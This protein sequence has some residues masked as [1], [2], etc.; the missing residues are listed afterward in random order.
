MLRADGRLPSPSTICG[1]QVVASMSRYEHFFTVK[2]DYNLHGNGLSLAVA[3][4]LGPVVAL[5]F[6]AAF[7]FFFDHL[8]GKGDPPSSPYSEGDSSSVADPRGVASSASGPEGAS[9]SVP[10]P[11][12]NHPCPLIPKE[13]RRRSLISLGH[14]P[15][16]LILKRLFVGPWSRKSIVI[17]LRY[18]KRNVVVA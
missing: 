1:L 18:W 13:T 16:P 10:D 8:G 3:F 4:T 14:R 15:R 17:V 9:S 5:V 12:D 6:F 11:E 7:V 2:F